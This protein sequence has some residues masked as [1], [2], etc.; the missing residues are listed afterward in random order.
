M[1][2]ELTYQNLVAELDKSFP[3]FAPYLGELRP[4]V[5][6]NVTVYFTFFSVYLT[7][8][9]RDENL[10][11]DV[12]LLLQQMKASADEATQ[13]VLHD[14]LLDVCSACREHDNDLYL[15]SQH[16]TPELQTSL[17]QIDR[18]WAAA[19]CELPRGCC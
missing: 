18:G 12:A 8:N 10:Q 1:T 19:A 4:S 13:I 6:D 11:L 7:E 9:W 15:L 16:L 3:Q 14:F 5:S 17:Q 2:T